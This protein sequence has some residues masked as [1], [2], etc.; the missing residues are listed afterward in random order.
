MTTQKF[1]Q[2]KRQLLWSSGA[3]LAVYAAANLTGCQAV[4][5]I[6]L[7]APEI[8]FADLS[9][10]DV[11]LSNVKFIVSVDAKNN[12]DVDI[13]L[14]EGK[15]ELSVMGSSFAN[16]VLKETN[17]VIPKKASK[18]IP[19]E[20]TVPTSLLIDTVRKLNLKDLSTFT[21]HL[22]GSARWGSGPFT[23]PFERK[24]DLAVLKS[25]ADMLRVLTR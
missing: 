17:L 8:S 23:V 22:K 14:S 1:D 9:V 12:N 2:T 7:K 16:G 5:P 20:F 25:L 4:P 3:G 18:S 21:Y 11:G 19:V 10:S 6:N 24:G 13:P 15:F